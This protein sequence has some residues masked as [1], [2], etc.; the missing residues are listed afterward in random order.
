MS[1]GI[2]LNNAIDGFFK[3]SRLAKRQGELDVVAEWETV[4]G[5]VVSN[6]STSVDLRNRVLYVKLD[7]ASL[8]HEL[9]M[10]KEKIVRMMND[11]IGNDVINN[12]KL[13]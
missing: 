9:S 3:S 6:H 7:S 12:I 4:M 10:N 2:D 8:R 11:H 1:D 13:L 5:H